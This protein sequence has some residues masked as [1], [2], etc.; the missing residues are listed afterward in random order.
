MRRR[1]ILIVAVFALAGCGSTVA[2]SPVAL[3]TVVT[4]TVA[5]TA[6]PTAATATPFLEPTAEPPTETPGPHLVGETIAMNNGTDAYFL[7]VA[8]VKTFAPS[9]PTPDA[10]NKYVIADIV[11]QGSSGSV[12][13][14]P[15][16]FTITDDDGYV[17]E[18]DPM[19][20]EP[21][22]PYDITLTL[23]KKVRGW[24][25]FQVP[26]AMKAGWVVTGD[27]KIRFKL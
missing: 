3:A 17:Y 27:T 21:A 18:I 10:G 26:K 12:D 6:T 8:A 7:T 5:P 24:L 14:S 19:W 16:D 20:K 1:N 11:L 25:T 2:P 15:L 9:D 4:V 13:V 23:N 22:L